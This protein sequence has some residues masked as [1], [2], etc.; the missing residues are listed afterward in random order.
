MSVK[1]LHHHH[2]H[3]RHYGIFSVNDLVHTI[4]AAE[5]R[6]CDHGCYFS[7]TISASVSLFYVSCFQRVNSYKYCIAH[8]CNKRS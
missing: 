6:N 4:F 5:D 3:H 2:H 7:K 8:S 1:S